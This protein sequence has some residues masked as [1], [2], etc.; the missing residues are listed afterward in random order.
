MLTYINRLYQK[1]PTAQYFR[2][3]KHFLVTEKAYAQFLQN[4]KT[5]NS[6]PEDARDYYA[7]GLED[8]IVMWVEVPQQYLFWRNMYI[9]WTTRAHKIPYQLS[10]CYTRP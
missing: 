2:E 3:L 7:Y 8:M 6:R 1:L 10:K 5:L 9:G 4:A